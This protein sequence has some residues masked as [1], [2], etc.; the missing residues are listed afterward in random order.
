MSHGAITAGLT[1]IYFWGG[2]QL[3]KIYLLLPK[4]NAIPII[5]GDSQ[6]EYALS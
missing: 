3:V 5:I 2:W 1:E 4:E 6:H